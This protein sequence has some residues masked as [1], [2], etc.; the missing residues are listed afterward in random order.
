[1]M[2]G[3]R[4]EGALGLSLKERSPEL[5]DMLNHDCSPK[6]ISEGQFMGWTA[7]VRALKVLR[8]Q[9][10][11]E[12]SNIREECRRLCMAMGLGPERVTAV[13]E[14]AMERDRRASTSVVPTII[15]DRSTCEK[16]ANMYSYSEERGSEDLEED[17]SLTSTFLAQSGF[18]KGV[19]HQC[20][21]SRQE[22]IECLTQVS[23]MMVTLFRNTG[24]NDLA[25][26]LAQSQPPGK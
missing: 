24:I 2:E 23:S 1:M 25:A 12:L 20:R 9:R 4:L 14:K 6:R 5:A 15:E 17:G 7:A 22:I 8:V 19:L 18:V 26:R 3:R 21:D 10:L 16:L 11:A 13:L